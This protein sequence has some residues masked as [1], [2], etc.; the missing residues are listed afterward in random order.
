MPLILKP[1]PPAK[2]PDDPY[3]TIWNHD[4]VLATFKFATE[5]ERNIALKALEAATSSDTPVA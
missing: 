3:L 2:G 4:Q 5:E 1:S